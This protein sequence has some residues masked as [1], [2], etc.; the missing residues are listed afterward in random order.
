M[1]N[2][3]NAEP[4]TQDGQKASER[5]SPTPLF[6][7]ALAFRE[8]NIPPTRFQIDPPI[9]PSMLRQRSTKKRT[10]T[11]AFGNVQ[12]VNG[13]NS[14]TSGSSLVAVRSSPRHAGPNGTSLPAGPEST[15]G[16]RG[17][18]SPK[19]PGTP[20]RRSGRRSGLAI[21]VQTGDEDED[22]EAD[23][24]AEDDEEATAASKADDEEEEEEDVRGEEAEGSSSGE[25]ESGDEATSIAVEDEEESGSAA[26]SEE[27]E[28]DDEEE[29]EV[30]VASEAD[31]PNDPDAEEPDE[32]EE[33]ESGSEEEEDDGDPGDDDA[34]GEEEG[35]DEDAEAEDDE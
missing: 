23:A 20:I 16:S 22:D 6:G 27:D 11:A 18:A 33:S 1:D 9:P 34:E 26:E 35:E 30:E 28:D 29:E 4:T 25:E 31:D 7:Y 21:V 14:T 19:M 17:S 15:N 13:I 3:E 24:P 8:H 10:A 12:K 2:K 5:L 32:D